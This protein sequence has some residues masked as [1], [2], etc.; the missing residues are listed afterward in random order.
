M[1]GS[2]FGTACTAGSSHISLAI[3]VFC[4]TSSISEVV[5]LDCCVPQGSFVGSLQ[6]SLHSEDMAEIIEAYVTGNHFYDT[7][8]QEHIRTEELLPFLNRLE[9]C[10]ISIKDWCSS[11]HLQIN[12]NKMEFIVF[13]SRTNLD[14]LC[15]ENVSLQL[16]SSVIILSKLPLHVFIILDNFVS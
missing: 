5:E 11:H 7:Q 15:Q 6:F 8:L 1:T 12:P 4:T 16:D 14:R 3:N 2:A 13:E 10:I 9:N